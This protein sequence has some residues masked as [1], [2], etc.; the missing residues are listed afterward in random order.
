MSV[1][2][3]LHKRSNGIQASKEDYGLIYG[4][5]D[6]PEILFEEKYREGT[7]I[8]LTN[9]MYP[10]LKII[11][12]ISLSI[13]TGEPVVKIKTKDGDEFNLGRQYANGETIFTYSFSKDDDYV[14]QGDP[15]MQLDKP[16]PGHKY[17]LD[18]LK[19]YANLF[20]DLILEK[21]YNVDK[22]MD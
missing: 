14:A 15:E 13:F 7:Y 2:A 3:D 1:W 18:E 8:I 4:L 10:F 16:H 5:M 17:T 9:G 21:H 11:L 19:D 22:Y 12:K 20:I 6:E